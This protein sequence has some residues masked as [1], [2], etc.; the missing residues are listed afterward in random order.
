MMSLLTLCCNQHSTNTFSPIST[1]DQNDDR[2]DWTPNFQ[3][4]IHDRP[5]GR[6][7]LTELAN[8]LSNIGFENQPIDEGIPKSHTPDL[9]RSE[10]ER[11][12]A[13]AKIWHVSTIILIDAKGMT[14]VSWVR[15]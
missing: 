12:V 6:A 7:N 15:S 2:M 9:A 13:R 4:N 10:L 14:S 8:N 3:E 1:D 5:N 11:L